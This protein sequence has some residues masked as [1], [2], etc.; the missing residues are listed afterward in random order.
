ML[1][2]IEVVLWGTAV[3]QPATPTVTLAILSATHPIVTCQ[4]ERPDPDL[5]GAAV[6]W[7]NRAPRVIHKEKVKF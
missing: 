2:A 5:V 1:T 7:G 4:S 3:S 6:T